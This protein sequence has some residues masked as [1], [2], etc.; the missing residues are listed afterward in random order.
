MNVKRILSLVL[1]LIML[2]GALLAGTVSAEDQLYSD[3]KTKRWSYEDIKYVTEKGLMNGT[4]DGIFSPAETMTRAMV[5]TVLHRLQGEPKPVGVPPFTDVP[6]KKWYSEA[7][8]WASENN[9]VNGVSDGIFAPMDTITREQL[10]AIIMRYAPAEYIITEERADITGYADYKRVHDYAREALSWANAIGLI[11][12]K[13]D[14][15]LAPREG[16]TREQFA[17]ILRRFKEYDNYKFS[18]YYNAA[19][20]ESGYTKPEYPLVTDADIYVAVDGKDT[21]DGSI[22]SPV[23]TF[24]RAKDMVRELKKTKTDGIKVAFKAGN[25]GELD[26]LTFTA[27][28]A[29]TAE[30]PI[31]YCAYGDGDVLFSNGVILYAEDFVA[32]SEDEK[33]LFPAEAVGQIKKLELGDLLPGELQIS[34]YLFSE[35]DGLIWLARNLNKNEFGQDIYYTNMVGEAPDRKTSILL[36]NPL[37]DK[38]VPKFSTIEGLMVKGMLRCGYLFDRFDVKSYDQSTGVME[39]DVDKYVNLMPDMPEGRFD[40]HGGFAQE[41]RMESKIFFYNLAEFLDAQGEYWVDR[42]TNTLYVYNPRGRYTFC[43]GGTMMTLEEGADHLSFVGLEFNGSSDTMIHSNAD[44]TTYNMCIFANVGGHYAVRADGVNHFV[45]ENCDSHNFVDGSLYV[46]SDADRLNIVPA[47]N[48]IRN[49]AF[50]DF[51]LSEYWSN[52]VRVKNDVGCL[53]EHNE[54]RNGGHGAFRYDGCIDLV[55][56]YNVFDSLMQSTQDYGAVYTIG[57]TIYRDNVIRYNLFTNITGKGAQLGAAAFGIYV[58]DYSCG[59]E[60]YGNLFVN[61]G[62]HAVVLHDGRDNLVYDNIIVALDQSYSGDFLMYTKGCYSCIGDLESYE[63]TKFARYL[64]NLPQEGTEGYELWKN[65]WPLMYSYHTDADRLDE[66]EC[67]FNIRN[68]IL[69]NIMFGCILDPGEV[70]EL[71]AVSEGNLEH[72]LTENPY[73]ANPAHGDYTIVSGLDADDGKY[74]F[75]LSMVGRQ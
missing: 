31:T 70:Y 41:G 39:I 66:V 34:N 54:F 59:Q 64:K 62:V 11:T 12:G 55:L 6:T 71:F 4:G 58:D 40:Y 57:S 37:K 56:Q 16:A 27:E 10:A 38:V 42:K 21:N 18:V 60:I 49:S 51:G 13:T 45:F 28:D 68:T 69:N 7:V 17:A 23:A 24:A 9:I 20:Y 52:A 36:K 33:S 72:E 25:Y 30:C 50:Y 35:V 26:N 5:V 47:G 73:F 75:D 3:V 8:A 63:K 65:R 29:G 22:N 48:V 44:Y 74:L 1:S 32:V 67:A 15:T 14:T 43:T 46:I 53:V 61:G 2:A 19:V